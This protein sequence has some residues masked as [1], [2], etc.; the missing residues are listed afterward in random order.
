MKP[1]TGIFPAASWTH[2]VESEQ[3]QEHDFANLILEFS[4]AVQRQDLMMMQ[5]CESELKTMFRRR[6]QRQRYASPAVGKNHSL[7]GDNTS[8]KASKG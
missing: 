7:G 8:Q 4:Y 1:K 6:R 2:K 5:Y 3:L